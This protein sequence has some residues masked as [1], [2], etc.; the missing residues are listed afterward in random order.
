M[1]SVK[2]M[3]EADTEFATAL[4]T[5]EEWGYLREDFRRLMHFEPEGC[6]VA[7][8]NEKRVGM[9]STTSYGDYAF[10]G[11]LIVTPEERGRGIGEGLLRHAVNYLVQREV[12][13]IE[14]D[15]VFGAASLYRRLGFRDKYLSLRLK[16]RAESH[17]QEALPYASEMSDEVVCFDR[18]KTGLSRERVVRELLAEFADSVYVS[19]SEALTGYAIVRPREGGY[20]AMGPLVAED[21]DAAD[22]LLG[23]I[24]ANYRG[25][26][27]AI[28][29]PE[30]NRVAVRLLLRKGFNYFE[31][32]L[33]M[34][35]GE[36]RDYETNVYGIVAAE[37]G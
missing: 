34:Y 1:L 5:A 2:I 8:R 21:T 32:S 35:F 31:P 29:V 14:L 10:L 18:R 36:R 24:M 12:R 6:F 22:L 33:R 13:T 9:A 19:G 37:K 11:S 28:G 23:S 30:V 3:T 7:W 20:F 15:G 16:G 27:L 25:E 4:A 26:I 17:G